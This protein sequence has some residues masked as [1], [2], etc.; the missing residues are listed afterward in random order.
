MALFTILDRANDLRLLIEP[1]LNDMVAFFYIQLLFD[2]IIRTSYEFTCYML[3]R[4][5]KLGS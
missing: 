2:D 1:K 4:G 5:N 3:L